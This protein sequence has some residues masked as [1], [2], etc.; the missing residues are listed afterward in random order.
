MEKVTSASFLMIHSSSR[1]VTILLI[2][3][4]S[5]FRPE[6]NRTVRK[7]RRQRVAIPGIICHKPP[8]LP[9]VVIAQIC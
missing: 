6:R 8:V 7:Q 9:S 5:V 2:V 4:I 3:V 1:L